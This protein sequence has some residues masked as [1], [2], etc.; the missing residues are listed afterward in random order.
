MV[1]L[2]KCGRW[3]TGGQKLCEVVDWGG[4]GGKCEIGGIH[5]WEVGD[6]GL[7][8]VGGGRLAPPP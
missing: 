1:S 2:V 8:Y 6:W 4:G 5:L 3:E 7:K